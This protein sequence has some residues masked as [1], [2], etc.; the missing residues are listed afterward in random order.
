MRTKEETVEYLESKGYK[1]NLD[2]FEVMVEVD[3]ILSQKEHKKLEKVI[4]D[5]G[6]TSSW[7]WRVVRDDNK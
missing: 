1:T 7:G 3:H 4:E 5:Y 2:G 6:Y